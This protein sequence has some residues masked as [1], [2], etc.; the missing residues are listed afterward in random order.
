MTEQKALFLDRKQGSFIVGTREI[1]KPQPGELL[2][3]IK[4]VALN[5]VEW[6]VQTYGMFVENYP[7]ILGTDIAGEVEAVGGGVEGFV[8]GDRV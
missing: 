7:A 8:K 3:K 4:A 5:P 6:K 2:V 1:E